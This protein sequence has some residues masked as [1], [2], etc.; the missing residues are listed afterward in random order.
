MLRRRMIVFLAAGAWAAALLVPAVVPAQTPAQTRTKLHPVPAL[1]ANMKTGPALGKHIPKFSLPDQNGRMRNFEN[2][3]GPKG[4]VL[5]FVRS[6][7]W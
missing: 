7:D 2:L 5:L 6:A 3:K 4:L 1:D